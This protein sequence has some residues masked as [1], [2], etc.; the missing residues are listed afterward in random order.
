MRTGVVGL[1][2]LLEVSPAFGQDTKL[3]EA[4]RDFEAGATAFAVGQFAVAAELFA[5]SYDHAPRPGTLFS[6]AQ[7]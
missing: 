1:L 7:A 5:R 4:K 2:V 6:L 3:E